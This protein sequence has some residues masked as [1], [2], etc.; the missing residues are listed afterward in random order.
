MSSRSTITLHLNRQTFRRSTSKGRSTNNR[1]TSTCPVIPRTPMRR[2]NGHSNRRNRRRMITRNPS[3]NVNALPNN[4]IYL[5]PF[6]TNIKS[7]T[8]KLTIKTSR[9]LILLNFRRSSHRRNSSNNGRRTPSRIIEITHLTGVTT[10]RQ[11]RRKARISARVRS[12]MNKVRPFIAQ[13]MRLPRRK[14][15]NKLRT[16]ITRCGRDRSTMRRPVQGLAHLR[17]QNANGRRR[18]TS[19]RRRN[20]PRSKATSTP[21]FINSMTT[22]WKYRMRRSN[23][24]TM[25]KNNILLIRGR[26]LNR[27][28]GRSNARTM[29]TRALYHTNNRSG[30]GA[31]QISKYAR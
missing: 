19:Y 22:S 16:T 12:D 25:S 26:Y 5:K 28:R 24:T 6:L 8:R 3:I 13:L 20:P 18:L 15:S 10:S 29:M 30:M 31:F 27:R 21:M 11:N 1:S 17:R 9:M 2:A 23:M 7:S 4:I 14:K